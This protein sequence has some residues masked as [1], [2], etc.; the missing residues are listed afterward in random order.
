MKSILIAG[1]VIV[2]LALIAYSAGILTQLRKKKINRQVLNFL[3]LGILFDVS[4][5]ICMVI[6]SSTGGLSLHGFIGYSSLMGMLTDVIF[7]FR[8]V[9][10]NGLNKDPGKKFNTWSRIAYIYWVLA[11]ITGAIIVMNR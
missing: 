6:G 1:V 8:F 4:S 9:R 3:S 2:K 5:T 10:Q 11:Y 7:T